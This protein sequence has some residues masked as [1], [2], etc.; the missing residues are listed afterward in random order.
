MR[1]VCVGWL[2]CYGSDVYELCF[3]F[4]FHFLWYGVGVGGR[5][6]TSIGSIKSVGSGV[7]SFLFI[8]NSG[9]VDGLGWS[10]WMGWE[11]SGI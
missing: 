6:V 8:M 1:D 11:N 3:S 10:G 5:V 9:W 4:L 2:L 7:F